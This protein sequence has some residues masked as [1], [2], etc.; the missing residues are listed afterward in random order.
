MVLPLTILII[1]ALIVLLLNFYTDFAQQVADHDEK[2]SE[3]YETKE[4]SI[5]R[6]KVSASQAADKLISREDFAGNDYTVEDFSGD[7]FAGGEA[8]G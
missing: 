6:M 1:M 5:M 2:R 7:D 8:F 3:M 4:I